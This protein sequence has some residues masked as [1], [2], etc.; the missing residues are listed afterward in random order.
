MKTS[1]KEFIRNAFTDNELQNGVWDNWDGRSKI[2]TLKLINLISD[3]ID[4]NDV[5]VILD[6]GAR[7]GL[8][9]L[10]FN[11]WFPNAQIYTFEPT[12]KG[13]NFAKNITKD[14]DNIKVLNYAINS[15][16][17]LTKFYEVYTGNIGASSLLPI[18]NH[19]RSRPNK[20]QEIEV[21]C[22]KLEEWFKENNINKV[23]IVWMDVQGAEDI[24]FNSFG[25]VLQNVEAI[26][27]EATI[28]PLYEG[29]TFKNEI[30]SI[31]TNFNCIDMTPEPSNTEMDVIYLNK[32]YDTNIT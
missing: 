23:D 4:F 31:L 14:I 10:E 8:Q 3:K 21:N 24:V 12:S 15:F 1:N 20:Q 25:E 13:F 7:D 30:D 32:K 9:S 19:P 18:S 26:A 11:R 16:T 22:I 2:L 29:S 6:I 27:T 17:G 5:K 28:Q